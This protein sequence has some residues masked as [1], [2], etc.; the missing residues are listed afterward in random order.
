[1]VQNK[2]EEYKNSINKLMQEW[3]E[4][5]NAFISDG[6]VNPERW[7]SQEVRPLFLLKEA[8]GEAKGNKC[9]SLIDDHLHQKDKKLSRMWKRV[10]EWTYGVMNTTDVCIA[11][12][13]GWDTDDIDSY[14]NKYLNQIAIVN[15]K[16]SNGMSTSNMDD[17]RNCAKEDKKYILR[18]LE[19]CDP[20]VIIC[21]YTAS[22]L[23]ILLDK[24]VREVVHSNLIYHI[25]LNKHNVIVLDYWHPANQYPNIMNY[26][27]LMGMYQQALLG[28][29]R[30]RV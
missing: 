19:L 13:C 30:L 25:E 2:V 23:D 16:K 26:Y 28:N 7:F 17:I 15:V 20:T 22:V 11:P 9:W 27:G 10:G 12:Y 1:M 6:V 8:Y 14:D 18:E 21:G 3:G 29:Q 24:K 5:R 4:G